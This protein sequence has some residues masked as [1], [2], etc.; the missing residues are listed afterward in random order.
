MARE[1]QSYLLFICIENV[2]EE[3][4]ED[5]WNQVRERYNRNVEKIT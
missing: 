1:I 3:G 4:I 5:I 2:C